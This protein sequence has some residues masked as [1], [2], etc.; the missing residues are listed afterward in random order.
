MCHG[1]VG[2]R[3]SGLR[4]SKHTNRPPSLLL[5]RAAWVYPSV[6]RAGMTG[7]GGA[8]GERERARERE[9]ERKRA[10]ESARRC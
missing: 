1:W 5:L 7:V 8:G 9:S 2:P 10:R 3:L 6:E 4:L